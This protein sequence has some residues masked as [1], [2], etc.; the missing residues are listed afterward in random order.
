MFT[1]LL[2]T[3]VTIVISAYIVWKYVLRSQIK[4]CVMDG[5]MV[6]IVRTAK[7]CILLVAEL[8]SFYPQA[9]GLDCEWSKDKVSLLQIGHERLTILIRMNLIQTVPI[10][11]TQFLGDVTILKC[12]VGIYEDMNKLKRDWNIPVCGCIELNHILKTLVPNNKLNELFKKPNMN[13]FRDGNNQTLS[14][15][16]MSLLVLQQL[17]KYKS[18]SDDFRFHENW[19][20]EWLSEDQIF[21][22]A[23]DALKGTNSYVL[24]SIHSAV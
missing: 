15:K 22:A 8:R 16:S 17:M 7:E 12:G 14:L 11:L 18:F 6:K 4:S 3:L 19:D 24:H 21:Y 13:K 23:D 10:E 9:V 5:K 20:N 1:L 2:I